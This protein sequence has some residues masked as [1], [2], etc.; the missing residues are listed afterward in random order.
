MRGRF[1]RTVAMVQL[2]VFL[3]TMSSPF[4]FSETVGFAGDD[5]AAGVAGNVIADSGEFSVSAE[6]SVV[7]ETAEPANAPDSQTPAEPAAASEADAGQFRIPT[8]ESEKEKPASPQQESKTDSAPVSSEEPAAGSQPAPETP[9]APAAPAPDGEQPAAPETPASPDAADGTGETPAVPGEEDGVKNE[10]AEINGESKAADDEETAPRITGIVIEGNNI[11]PTDEIIKVL[12]VRIGDLVVE[13]KIQRDIQALF[14]MGYFTDVRVD[15]R[16]FVGGIK[17]VFGVLENPVINEIV[18]EGNKMVPADKLTSL[19]ETKVGKILNT[20]E[21]YGDVGAIN[22]YYDE[23]LG[24]LLKPSHVKDL[25]WSEEGK[26]IIDL[27]EGMVIGEIEIT[28][29]TVFSTEELSKYI[30][31]KKGDLFN[32]KTAKEITDQIAKLYEKNDYILDTIRPNIEPEKNLMSIRIVEATVEE[33]QIEG[34]TKTKDYVILRNMNTKVGQVLKRRRLQKD[35][36]R[37]NSLGYFSSV[38]I[39]PEAGSEMGKVI[40]VLKVKE[41][42]TATATIG[43]GY[44]GGGSGAVRSGISGAISLSERNFKGTGWAGNIQWQRGVTADAITAG[45]MNPAIN[46]NRDSIALSVYRH[47]YMELSQAV[48]GSNPLQY[49]YYD[50]QR[51]GGTLTYGR[52]L[53]EDLTVYLTLKTEQI[54]LM[55]SSISDYEPV[56]MFTGHSNSAILSAVYDTRDDMFNPRSGRY[57]SAAYQ[58]AGGFMG[59]DSQFDKAV[60]EVR[61]YIP[62]GKSSSIALRAWGGTLS[63]NSMTTEYF[64]VGGADSLRGYHDNIFMGTR[65]LVFNAEYRFPIA[66]IKILSGAV[67]VDA[68]NAWFP[69]GESKLY[70]DAGIGLRLSL[71]TLGVGVIRLDYAVGDNGSRTTIGFGQSF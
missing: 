60:V 54:E 34:N 10:N 18:F 32:Q 3:I 11:V 47:K 25:S 51:T 13:S 15:T 6:Y 40:L 68:G 52:P 8:A 28:G 45:I 71:P 67:F 41:E 65:M 38:N 59:G 44:T 26:L 42:K 30:T 58:T 12:S 48:Q 39:D 56:G 66:K 5:L 16:Y 70:T 64:Y 2:F 1:M 35:L 55:R 20:K 21:L 4:A 22:Q 69:G 37:L 53:S 33:I 61:Q 7:E 49:A 14:D 46:S 27:Q 31:F 62:I 57:I 36:E 50:D 63:G 9:A 24:Y 23:E 19:M 17:L 43:L 29:N